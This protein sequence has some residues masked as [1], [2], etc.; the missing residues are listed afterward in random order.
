LGKILFVDK[1]DC[2]SSKVLVGRKIDYIYREDGSKAFR[3]V[4]E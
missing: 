1:G 2:P 4:Y 3:I